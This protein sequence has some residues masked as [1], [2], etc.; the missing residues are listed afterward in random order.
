MT[1]EQAANGNGR[2]T[3]SWIISVIGL[4]VMIS[5]AVSTYTVGRVDKIQDTLS[6][7]FVQKADYVDDLREMKA[8][9]GKLDRKIDRLLYP[10]K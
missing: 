1:S 9:M 8:M 6:C 5:M 2:T 3:I 7:S 4:L 10:Q